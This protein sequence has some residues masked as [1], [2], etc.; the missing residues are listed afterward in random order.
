MQSIVF[1][2]FWK[3]NFPAK[4]LNLGLSFLQLTAP[5]RQQNKLTKSQSNSVKIR[6]S[7]QTTK[8]Y[9]SKLRILNQNRAKAFFS[10]NIC[11][12]SKL[13]L[14]FGN[15]Q[16]NDSMEFSRPTVKYGIPCKK[17]TYSKLED[18]ENCS[19]AS[20][21]SKSKIST[22]V[23]LEHFQYLHARNYRRF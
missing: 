15:V 2:L 8:K 9:E 12:L 7:K 1:I 10:R 14:D 21:G 3:S 23:A 19:T 13:C 20:T 17:R 11:R 4:T 6:K 16:K 18:F 22:F 5:D